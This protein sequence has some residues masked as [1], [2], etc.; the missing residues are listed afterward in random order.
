MTEEECSKW[1]REVCTV[2]RELKTKFNSVTKC[3]KV[4]NSINARE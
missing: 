2:S 1:P 4:K 3:E